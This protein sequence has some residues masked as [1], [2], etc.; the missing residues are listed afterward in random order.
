[1]N[2]RYGKGFWLAALSLSIALIAGLIISSGS[3]CGMCGCGLLCTACGSACYDACAGE[4]AEGCFDPEMFLEEPTREPMWDGPGSIQTTPLP[5]E[6]VTEK[7]TEKPT[8][9]PAPT[10]HEEETEQVKA[11]ENAAVREKRV[12]LKNDGTDTVT[13]LV[14]MNGS[15]LE[16]EYGEATEDLT[17]MVRAKKSDRVRILVETVGTRKWNARYGISSRRAERYEVTDTGL[18]LADGTLGQLD[19]TVPETLSDFIRWGAENYPADRYILLF[20]DHGGGPVYGFGYDEYQSYRSTLTIDEMQIALRDGGVYFDLIGMDCCLMSS[21]EVCCALYEYCD[22]TLLSED[23][24]PAI[25]WA[26]TGWLSALAENP[27]IPTPD[28]AS[29]VIGDSVQACEKNLENDGGTTLALMDQAYMK[30]LYAAWVDFAYANEDAL[31]NANYSQLRESSGGRVHPRIRSIGAWGGS[32]DATL[33]DYYITDILSVAQNIDSDRTEA[34]SA[35]LRAAI[36][37]YGA[38]SD[39]TT[40]TGLSVTLPYGDSDF[41]QELKRVFRAAGFDTAY[42]DW[43]EKFVSVE[44]SSQDDFF[45]FGNWGDLWG[46][47]GTADDDFNWDDWPLS[48]IWEDEGRTDEWADDDWFDMLFGGN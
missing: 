21:L 15:D 47:W 34:L 18:R 13:V 22:Y 39:E 37:R 44:S 24:E 28:L 46:G 6:N 10:P 43:L 11:E 31:L 23:F 14:L 45:D 40:L 27:A 42:I 32:D 41:Y 48:G 38:T 33:D 1:M 35:A 36:I 8:E 17:E 4:D 9:A 25:G 7:P 12:R 30:L 16:S 29:V 3:L 5:A 2:H 26:H 20:W 19:T